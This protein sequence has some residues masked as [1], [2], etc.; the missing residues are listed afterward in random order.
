MLD[1]LFWLLFSLRGRIGRATFATIFFSQV[2]A[3]VAF[4]LLVLHRIVIVDGAAEKSRIMFNAP[5][6][7][8]AVLCFLGVVFNWVSL[9]N[10]VK[11]LHDFG[12]SGWWLAAP[13]GVGF[14]GGLVG[15]L[16]AAFHL[17]VIALILIGAT[18]VVAGLGL[19]GLL[20]MMFF[21]RGD[22]ENGHPRGPQGDAPPPRDFAPAPR[23]PAP[24]GFSPAR[25]PAK[26][27]GRRGMRA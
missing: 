24:A 25:P 1:R 16:S 15:G 2:A 27:F 21:R 4:Q 9:A 19:L 13:A 5:P 6:A 18:T 14:V 8:L 7:T 3:S 17:G 23:D 10:H 12:W 20:I 11:R 22:G 26:G